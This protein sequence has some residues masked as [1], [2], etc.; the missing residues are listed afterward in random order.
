MNT[1]FKTAME[2]VAYKMN[3]TLSTIRQCL[4]W[5][6]IRTVMLSRL[7]EFFDSLFDVKPKDKDDYYMFFSWMISRKLAFSLVMVTGLGSLFLITMFHPLE[8]SGTGTVKT[9]RY[10]A[11]PLKFHK[12]DVRIL[13][14][15]GHTAYVGNVKKGNV[16]GT[17]RLYGK[18]GELIYEGAFENNRYNGTGKLYYGSGAL[19][20]SGEFQDNLY[21]GTG[22]GYWSNGSREYT[23]EYE[24]G[25][26]SGEGQLFD[27]SGN[28]VFTGVFSAGYPVYAQ[29]LGKT[30]K[31]AGQLYSGPVVMYDSGNE[32]CVDMPEIGAIY[33]ARPGDDTLE[34]DYTVERIYVLADHLQ[35]A[36]ED[37]KDISSIET[38]MGEA[39][40]QGFSNMVLAEAVGIKKLKAW[41]NPDFADPKL[42]GNQV[43]QE[44]MEIKSYQKDYDLYLYAF[45]YENLVYSFYSDKKS[46]HFSMYS[47]ENAG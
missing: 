23:G 2:A 44:V 20:Y 42:E 25:K 21:Q 4:R 3:S 40:Y 33:S 30:T 7:R 12:G 35:L 43:F 8:G 32:F 31:E 24:Q 1:L 5:E 10:D 45:T 17:G 34:G 36:G 28:L 47:I 29:F 16:S 38:V 18:N 26:K 39:G 46:G 14:A 13:A 11:L 27:S 6:Y 41:G 9:Y 37:H 15:D 19:K 22:T